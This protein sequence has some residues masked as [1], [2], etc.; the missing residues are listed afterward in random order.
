M[1]PKFERWAWLCAIAAVPGLLAAGM[2]HAAE[3]DGKPHTATPVKHLIII[4]GENRTFDHV[5]GVY[6]PSPGQTVSNL[7]SKGIVKEDGSPGANFGAAAQ[8]SVPAQSAY[9]I[10]ADAKTPYA[11]LPAPQLSGT[12]N[13][14]RLSDPPFATAEAASAAEHDLAPGD[15]R[16]LTTG[17]S[18]LAGTTGADTRIASASNLPNGPFQLAG[19]ALAYDA[20]TGDMVHR[21]YQMWQE[22]DCDA[23]FASP[24]NPSGCLSDLYPFAGT[25]NSA[26]YNDGSNAMGFYNMERGDAPY[27]RRLADDYTMSDNYHQAEMGGTMVEHLYIAMADTIFYSD[28]KGAPAMPPANLIADPSPQA[29]TVNRYANDGWYT[30][31][32]DET[33]PGVQPIVHYLAALPYAPKPNCGPGHYYVLNNLEPGYKADGSLSTNS[34]AIPPSHVRSIGD[35]L[36]EKGISFRFYGG[37]F[38]A[39]KAGQAKRYCGVCNPFQ[40][41]ASIMADAEKR[42]EH[43][44]DVQ[45]LFADI[46]A[47]TLPAVAYV[48]PDWWLDGHPHSSKLS[49]FEAFARNIV[50]RVQAKPELFE[51]TA[52]FVTFDEGGGYYDSGFIQPLDFFGDGPRIP[53][54]AVS[55]Y[56]KGGRV[57]HTYCDHASVVKFIERNWGLPPLTAR[58]RDNL[59]NPVMDERTAYVPANMPAIGDLFDM[60]RFQ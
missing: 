29:G 38:N 34:K 47:G 13:A 41:Q 50:E 12:P 3:A 10:S 56:T 9:Y 54:I 39:A 40:Y 22:S 51:E 7:L 59:P 48:K 55:P 27:L 15:M 19:P 53:F 35:A 46:A 5:F 32:A 4:I 21:F 18:G 6:K 31:C 45:D 49:L 60:F 42:A 28:G 36:A 8:F 52:I 37:G 44:K 30:A 1:P 23:A 11:S 26:K 33:Q 58:S 17:A 25:T 43:L 14:P 2:V 24:E 16:L 57:V 20:Y